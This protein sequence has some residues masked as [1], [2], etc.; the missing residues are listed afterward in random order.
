MAGM[1]LLLAG[2]IPA[3]R[4]RLAGQV[5]PP[6][7]QPWHDWRRLLRKRPL[8][9]EGTAAWGQW[10]PALALAA[11][12]V[13]ALLVPSFTLGMATAPL[14]DLVVVAGLLGLARAV[15]V[16]AAIDAGTAPG[17]L[18]AVRSVRLAALAEPAVVLV[19]FTVALVA[20]TTNL[21]AAVASLH[22]GAMPGVP[23]LLAIAGLVA[24]AVAV[25]A[26]DAA[27]DASGWHAAATEA[28]RALRRVV[29]LSLVA[30][31]LLPGGLA[32]PGGGPLDW[33][34][35]LVAWVAKLAVLGAACAVAG[36]LLHRAGQ[37][38]IGP[39][40]GA[41]VLLGLLAVLFLF[42]GQGLT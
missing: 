18:A 2:A 17:G 14:G 33:A 5:G 42:A 19:A 37:V 11:T 31:L 26:E 24:V 25:E 30:A 34:L 35:G 15:G 29:W 10:M 13:A 20:G 41:A 3:G 4:A 8:V 23:L 27:S 12:A 9:T 22:D 38:A 6:I 32:L 21:D 1:A 39:L 36:P 28:T 16:L 7:F 40:M